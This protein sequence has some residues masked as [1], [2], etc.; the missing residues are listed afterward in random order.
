MAKTWFGSLDVSP[1]LHA[2][3]SQWKLRKL[4]GDFREWSLC[5]CWR[6]SLSKSVRNIEN[7]ENKLKIS[8]PNNWM[9]AGGGADSDLRSGHQAITC[10]I[11]NA[12]VF[13]GDERS[14]QV[15]MH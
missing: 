11:P 15:L 6:H 1:P 3:T 5:H 10:D 14:K 8:A 4:P 9:R 2:L 12:D 13:L 7:A